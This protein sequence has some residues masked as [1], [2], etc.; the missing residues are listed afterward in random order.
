M[1]SFIF[2]NFKKKFLNGEV[3]VEDNKTEWTFLPVNS[4]IKDDMDNLKF[5]KNI[6]DIDSHKLKKNEGSSDGEYEGSYIVGGTRKTPKFTI[7]IDTERD[8]DEP[9]Y[10][11]EGNIEEFWRQFSIYFE[12]ES[13]LDELK[14]YIATYGGFY[15]IRSVEQF[16]NFVKKTETNSYICCVFGT[17]FDTS[18]NSDIDPEDYKDSEWLN[19]NVICPEEERPFEG[20]IDGNNI[21]IYSFQVVCNN[22]NNGIVGV[23]GEK[24]IVKNIR[25]R[26]YAMLLGSYRLGLNHLQ[27]SGSDISSALFVGKNYGTIQGCLFSGNLFMKNFVPEVYF[28]NNK[29]DGYSDFTKTRDRFG[30]TNQYFLNC[31]CVDSPGNV[32]PYVGYFNEGVMYMDPFLMKWELTYKDKVNRENRYFVYQF[33]Q[34]KEELKIEDDVWELNNYYLVWNFL[35]RKNDSILEAYSPIEE[36]YCGYLND[37]SNKNPYSPIIDS[38]YNKDGFSYYIFSDKNKFKYYFNDPLEYQADSDGY[39]TINFM[40]GYQEVEEGNR[41][42]RTAP[43]LMQVCTISNQVQKAFSDKFDSEFRRFRVPTTLLNKTS[44]L[45]EVGRAA[46]CN[47]TVAGTNYGDIISCKIDTSLFNIGNFVGFVGGLCGKYACGKIYYNLVHKEEEW[48]VTPK[49]SSLDEKFAI[50]YKKLPLLNSS[51][52]D[53]K[54]LDTEKYSHLLKE[55]LDGYDKDDF[56]AYY[57]LN[58]VIVSGGLFGIM[59]TLSSILKYTDIQYNILDIDYPRANLEN[60]F[61]LKGQDSFKGSA[62]RPSLQNSIGSICG[63]CDYTPQNHWNTDKFLVNIQNNQ[64]NHADLDYC[65]YVHIKKTD[66]TNIFTVGN[67]PAFYDSSEDNYAPYS[68]KTPEDQFKSLDLSFV[69]NENSYRLYFADIPIQLGFGGRL[70]NDK[71]DFDGY[72]EE[73]KIFFRKKTA[74][75]FEDIDEGKD[76]DNREKGEKLEYGYSYRVATLNSG[77]WKYIATTNSHGFMHSHICAE[78]VTHNKDIVKKIFKLD[79]TNYTN[80]KLSNIAVYDVMDTDYEWNKANGGQIIS[81]DFKMYYWDYNSSPYVIPFMPHEFYTD[82]LTEMAKPSHDEPLNHIISYTNFNNAYTYR[83]KFEYQ[84]IIQDE[85]GTLSDEQSKNIA[86]ELSKIRAIGSISGD[87]ILEDKIFYTTTFYYYLYNEVTLNS[88]EK[89]VKIY[90]SINN[91]KDTFSYAINFDEKFDD[92][93]EDICYS[94]DYSYNKKVNWGIYLKTED[95]QKILSK[96]HQAYVKADT[97]E[98]GNYYKSKE[99]IQGVL[100]IDDEGDLVAYYDIGGIELD[101]NPY[102]LNIGGS[103]VNVK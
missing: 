6:K 71:P 14:E 51:I 100:V 4:G 69:E 40:N 78:F 59:T 103:V 65:G 11:Y 66:W 63:Y 33:P 64:F 9:S 1:S 2:N 83:K 3:K 62:W 90:K 13:R 73:E 41:H 91:K 72:T 99:K 39:L 49:T 87:N 42:G 21:P 75:S 53:N 93:V 7:E 61:T 76:P 74:F 32:C 29:G 45:N 24:G 57:A 17:N 84:V 96:R 54:E 86:S 60:Y 47:G 56:N 43:G 101:Y 89:K 52:V 70:T 23:L 58:P 12:N 85:V 48:R 30:T 77:S 28:V 5:L 88:L 10:I 55:N 81:G 35:K 15:W 97:L 22:R 79:N 25:I 36:K 37:G 67:A 26:K 18:S 98:L 20:L 44:R 8:T 38:F 27:R 92:D 34:E 95:L 31:Y 82:G 19:F 68:V 94:D 80:N 16:N 46:Y 102:S 50:S